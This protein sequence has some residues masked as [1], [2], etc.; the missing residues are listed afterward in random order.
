MQIIIMIVFISLIYESITGVP[1]QVCC[2]IFK[3]SFICTYKNDSSKVNQI[4]ARV[5]GSHFFIA[6]AEFEIA[7]TFARDVNNDIVRKS[8]R[9]HV[10]IRGQTSCFEPFSNFAK[11]VQMQGLSFTRTIAP[12]KPES[13]FPLNEN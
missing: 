13:L 11:N 4:C 5:G 10:K 8:Q 6:E 9:N 1:V 7:S 2:Q 12:L 3:K